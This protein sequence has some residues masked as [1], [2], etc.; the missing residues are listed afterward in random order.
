MKNTV[1]FLS[2]VAIAAVMTGC[3]TAVSPAG[4]EFVL[5]QRQH[6]A[7][8]ATA[9]STVSKQDGVINIVAPAEVKG[10]GA[11]T[12]AFKFPEQSGYSVMSTANDI[13][14][15]TV[16]LKTRSFLL[17]KT[18]ATAEVTKAQIV[19]NKAAVAFT[20]LAGGNYTVDIAAIDATGA[21]IGSDSQ[22]VAVTEGQTATVSSK[23]QLKGSAAP[24]T[25][26]LG[27]NIDV[28]NGN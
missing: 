11:I 25:T 28:L 18:V 23:L 17:T 7:K 12:M 19:S 4:S 8:T 13:S 15:I 22:S 21:N 16:T 26:G 14:K 3:G 24:A 10:T 20:G 9:Q 27:V 5:T 1:K 2:T 6:L